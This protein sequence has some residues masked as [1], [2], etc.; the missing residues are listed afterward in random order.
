MTKSAKPGKG[1]P[2]IKRAQAL[3]RNDPLTAA[4]V[5]TEGVNRI[6]ESHGLQLSSPPARPNSQFL[7]PEHTFR[8]VPQQRL[9]AACRNLA[10]TARDAAAGI[11]PEPDEWEM[12]LEIAHTAV[13]LMADIHG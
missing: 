2:F 3:Y 8:T 6:L 10:H 4:I 9:E 1:A 13:Q 7:C 5:L 11:A 12:D